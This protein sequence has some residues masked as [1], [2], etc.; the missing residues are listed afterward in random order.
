[1]TSHRIKLKVLAERNPQTCDDISEAAFVSISLLDSS[2][3][4]SFQVR[5]SFLS[6]G[7]SWRKADEALVSFGDEGESGVVYFVAA[8]SLFWSL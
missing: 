8:L 2:A 1:M 6:Q 5:V 7:N 3:S 4:C